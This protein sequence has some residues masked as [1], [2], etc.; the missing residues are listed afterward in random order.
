[1]HKTTTGE[2]R[3]AIQTTGCDLSSDAG[4]LQKA[5]RAPTACKKAHSLQGEAESALA[6][7]EALK[8]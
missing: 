2:K 5:A 1:V 8:L 4:I 7:A 6:K 3:K